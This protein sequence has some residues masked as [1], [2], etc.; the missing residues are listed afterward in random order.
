ME[1][2]AAGADHLQSLAQALQF[3][4]EPGVASFKFAIARARSFSFLSKLP[5]IFRPSLL[6]PGQMVQ[7]VRYFPALGSKAAQFRFERPAT[8]L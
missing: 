7:A 3:F 2:V 6:L 4:L 1:L 8:L 5:L